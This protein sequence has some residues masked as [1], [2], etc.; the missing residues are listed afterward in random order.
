MNHRSD[1]YM[2][3][4]IVSLDEARA[5]RTM[6]PP[7]VDDLIVDAARALRR[8]EGAAAVAICEAIVS[9]APAPPRGL[10]LLFTRARARAAQPE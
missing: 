4:K 1:N 9:D 10:L 6:A 3:D 5:A 2:D 8:Y 7:D